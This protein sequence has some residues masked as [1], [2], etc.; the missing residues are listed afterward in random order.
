[1]CVG[2][3]CLDPVLSSFFLFYAE[4]VAARRLSLAAMS[5]DFSWCQAWTLERGLRGHDTQALEHAGFS[6]WGIQAELLW[7]MESFQTRDRN[8]FPLNTGP[9]GKSR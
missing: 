3:H 4:P 2:S 5:G 8:H 9:P 1:M 7:H 6:S